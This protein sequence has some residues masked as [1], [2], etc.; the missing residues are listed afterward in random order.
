MKLLLLWQK[1]ECVGDSLVA[2]NLSCL[3]TSCLKGKADCVLA[4]NCFQWE[5][6]AIWT[7][8]KQVLLSVGRICWNVSGLVKRND[9]PGNNIFEMGS[10][11][12]VRSVRVYVTVWASILYVTTHTFQLVKVDSFFLVYA[13]HLPTV[14]L[15]M[16][17]NKSRFLTQ[18]QGS[19]SPL[20]RH[21]LLL[22][23]VHT[24]SVDAESLVGK[25]E[26]GSSH[27]YSVSTIPFHL[28]YCTDHYHSSPAPIYCFIFFYSTGSSNKKQNLWWNL[29]CHCNI[30]VL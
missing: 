13:S 1:S 12:L 18:L 5:E 28:L 30:T 22:G 9:L 16:A 3:L 23:K 7:Q 10:Y 19:I 24:N 27:E 25:D 6:H 14:S 29:H 2:H 21:D 20:C 26:C 4:I 17:H 8:S 15:W 11:F